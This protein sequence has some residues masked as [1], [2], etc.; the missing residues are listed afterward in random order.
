MS[1]LTSMRA[2][3]GPRIFDNIRVLEFIDYFNNVLGKPFRWEHRC[4]DHRSSPRQVGRR[5]GVAVSA[6]GACRT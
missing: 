3:D 5:A 6:L 4:S 1:D 2:P